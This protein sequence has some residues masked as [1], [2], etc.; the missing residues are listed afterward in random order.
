[1]PPPRPVC[2]LPPSTRRQATTPLDDV[3]EAGG[4][5][6]P[7]G[8]Q[9]ACGEPDL[10]KA[11]IARFL[12]GRREHGPRDSLSMMARL[13]AQSLVPDK[14]R[15]EGPCALHTDHL[16]IQLGRLERRRRIRYP[17]VEHAWDVGG[18]GPHVGT[19]LHHAVA[20]RRPHRP[21]K[22]LLPCGR[23]QLAVA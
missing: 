5:E 15:G 4:L 12:D 11:V 1:L 6:K 19:D 3:P 20:I 10:A 2:A 7:P 17:A 22:Q 13:N 18:P 8:G 23:W 14:A 16:A 21:E 9:I